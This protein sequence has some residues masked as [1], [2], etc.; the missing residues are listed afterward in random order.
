MPNSG[1][2]GQR[3]TFT[4]AGQAASDEMR[5]IPPSENLR[6]QCRITSILFDWVF[7]GPI[8]RI[9]QRGDT[10]T[11]ARVCSGW[12]DGSL[13]QA[14]EHVATAVVRTYLGELNGAFQL[15]ETAPELVVATP[16]GQLHELGALMAASIAVSEG[17]R[18][19][20]LGP[21][22]PAATIAEP[23]LRRE[24][25]AVA[26][27]IL[28]PLDD[29]ELPGELDE[30]A[31]LKHVKDHTFVRLTEEGEERESM[32]FIVDDAGRVTGALRHSNVYK[33]VDD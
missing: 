6:A 24:A 31:R 15:P 27:S 19:T 5:A 13:R 1:W 25:R 32:T 23:A 12:R 7:D 21:N 20:Y 11:F 33:R 26:L 14:H 10:I 2:G 18:A 22:L 28:Y 4:E 9:T 29:P 16:L 3:V 30:L 17:W 8:N